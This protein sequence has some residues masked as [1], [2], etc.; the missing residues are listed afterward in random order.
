MIA[1]KCVNDHSLWGGG[2]DWGHRL[3]SVCMGLYQ[4]VSFYLMAKVQAEGDQAV[5]AL[6]EMMTDYEITQMY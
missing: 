5:C 6:S 3:A 2:G 4:S 1:Q